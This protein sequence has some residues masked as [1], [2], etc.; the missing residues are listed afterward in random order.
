MTCRLKH[1][2]RL[3]AVV[4][5]ALLLAVAACA[6]DA[7]RALQMSVAFG[8]LKNTV[9]MN[10]ETRAEV[11][12][13]EKQARAAAADRNYAGAV[14][15]MA[16]GMALMRGEPWTP[17]RALNAAL[18]VK[19][20]RAVVE[21]GQAIEVTLSQLFPLDETPR[22]KLGAKLSLMVM[23]PPSEDAKPQEAALKTVEALE[24][25]DWMAKP[26]AIRV[27][28]PE[29]ADGN[30]RL[31][32]AIAAAGEDAVAEAPA[33]RFAPVHVERGLAARVAALKSRLPKTGAKLKEESNSGLLA[34]LPAA[35]YRIA[36]YDLASAGE[37]DFTRISF[38]D[39]LKEAAAALDALEAGRNPWTAR[40]GDFRMAYRSKVDNTLQ[41]YRLFVPASY[42][43]G[44][45]HPLILAL[46]GMGGTENAYFDG[47]EKGQFKT[48][49]EQRGYLV[50]CPKGRGPASMYAGDAATDV[51]DVL[52]EVRRDW[53]IDPD[54]IYLTGHSMGAYG[55][56][57]LAMANP[58]V[59]AALAPVA[60]G[61]NPA[62]VGKIAH[63]PQLVVHGDADKTVPVERSRAMV[64]AGKKA[65]AQIK[66]IEVPGGDHGSVAARTFQEVFDWFDAHRRKPAKAVT[67]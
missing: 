45:P 28:V 63:I 55:T 51:L 7:A 15:Q 58:E 26:P 49:A 12:R 40:R 46:H 16:Q 38:S 39:E 43:G 61:G 14:K 18:V 67:P 2:F 25:P 27:N 65:G 9:A 54:C 52:A 35:E 60:G 29:V 24:P 19:L 6:Q 44:K 59:F 3:V 8:T 34:A 48:Y 53:N 4:L 17:L 37:I 64:E 36:L 56:W 62:W 33:R 13:L 50:A 57:S 31:F 11:E 21:P 1:A 10:A 47:Y 23:A 5:A 30:Y 32:V 20:D 42:D 41:P 22:G 66:Y